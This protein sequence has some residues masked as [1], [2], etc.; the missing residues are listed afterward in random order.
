MS[1]EEIEPF[2]RNVIGS[3]CPVILDIPVQITD[4]YEIAQQK[5]LTTIDRAKQNIE[6]SDPIGLCLVWAYSWINL[7]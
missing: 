5:V 6:R 4:L 7:P 3:D 1:P 2:Q